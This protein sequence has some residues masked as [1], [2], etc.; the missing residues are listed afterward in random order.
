MEHTAIESVV[1]AIL[2]N[3]YIPKINLET[4]QKLMKL[5]EDEAKKMNISVV[6]AIADE[7][8]HPIAIHCMDNAY[9]ASFDVAINKAFTSVALKMSTR[10]LKELSVPGGSLYGVQ[11]TNQ[12]KIVIFGGGVPLVYKDRVIGGLG[13]SGGSEEQDTYLAD[14]GIRCLK[15]VLNCH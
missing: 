15:E 8:A 6:T 7:G 10:Q 5:V 9:I 1:K 12:G 11:Y 4:A 14:Y 13:V 3:I 2:D